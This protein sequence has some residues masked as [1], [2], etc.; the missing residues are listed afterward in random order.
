MKK[1]ELQPTRENLIK[2]LCNDTLNRNKDLV[3][4]YKILT[5]QDQSCT[6]ALD[7]KWG[8]GKTFFVRQSEIIIDSCN[9]QSSIDMELRERV[10]T[11]LRLSDNK[12]EFESSIISVYYDAWVND[13]DTEPIFSLIYEITK[14]ISIV[15]RCKPSFAVH[16]L[17]QLKHYILDE[18]ITFV[19]SVNLEQ[20]QHTIKHYYGI[21]FDSGRY[22]DRFFDLRV[23]IP[24]VDMED[25]YNDLGI[26]NQYYIDII[27]R[28]V[29]KIFNLEL[30]E[31]SKFYSQI[32]VAIKKYLDGNIVIDTTFADGK[33]RN[34]IFL[35]IVPLLIGL[36]IA[37]NTKYYEFISGQNSEPLVR[38]LSMERDFRPFDIMKNSNES[39]EIL[40][41][42]IH[43]TTEELVN[44]VY[45]AIFVHAYTSV[46]D[47]ITLGECQFS[48]E[49][50][51]FAIKVSS[52]MSNFTDLS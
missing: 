26:N 44:R 9:P 41:E 38:L 36:K 11:N 17:E 22:L 47:V 49:S 46:G 18:R 51:L 5:N 24:S 13:N 52:M 43:I 27:I 19:F 25:L 12:E 42:S 33:G 23:S 39:F 29:I 10:L 2:T 16:L 1:Y 3:Y 4:F 30:R 20:L 7:G 31:I 14:Q 34:F 15:D 45:D 28:R 8:S 50:K 32:R 21:N 48:M 35:C 6:I 40:P 37:D